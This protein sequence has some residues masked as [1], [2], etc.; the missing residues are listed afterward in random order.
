MN[1]NITPNKND[2]PMNIDYSNNMAVVYICGGKFLDYNP[3]GCGNDIELKPKDNIVCKEC[4]GRIFY[5]KRTKK[6]VQF[7]AR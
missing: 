6:M 2:I 1:S 5:K 4:N 7:E 3:I